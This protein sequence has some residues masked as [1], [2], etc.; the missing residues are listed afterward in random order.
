LK[1]GDRWS[2]DE[3]RHRFVLTPEEKRVMSFVIAAL[4][5]GLAT[6]CYREAQPQPP[7]LVEKKHPIGT[8]NHR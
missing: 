1:P 6:K 8:T 2:W 3:L 4:L 5:L 7:S